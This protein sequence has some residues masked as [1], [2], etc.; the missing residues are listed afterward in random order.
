M[1]VLF[2]NDI[3][4]RVRM[5]FDKSGR[6]LGEADVYMRSKGDVSRSIAKWSNTMLD[7]EDL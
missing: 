5:H 7:G 2:G 4:T 6:S 3:V 1:Q